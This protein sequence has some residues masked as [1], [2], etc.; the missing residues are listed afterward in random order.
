VTKKKIKEQE[1]VKFISGIHCQIL[2]TKFIKESETW[3]HDGEK[4]AYQI[5]FRNSR[6]KT[7]FRKHRRNGRIILKWS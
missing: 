6:A 1:S 2:I 5:M 3:R 4:S 7:P